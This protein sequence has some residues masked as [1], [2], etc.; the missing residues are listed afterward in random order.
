MGVAFR[1]L[2]GDGKG[3]LRL[4]ILDGE[5]LPWVMKATTL[6]RGQFL[7]PGECALAARRFVHGES[8]NEYA[9]ARYVTSP[10]TNCVGNDDDWLKLFLGCI[11]RRFLDALSNF[12]QDTPP[13]F[14]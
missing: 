6:V 1:T 14:R 4:V 7:A 9:N 13:E 11:A 10:V 8:S 5:V 2:R 3:G 12:T